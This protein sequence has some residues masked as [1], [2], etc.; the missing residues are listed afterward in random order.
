MILAVLMFAA[1][2]LPVAAAPSSYSITISNRNAGHIYEAYQVFSGSLET[3][4]GENVLVDITWGSGVNGSDL[5]ATLKTLT[6]GETTPFSGATSAAEVAE[7]LDNAIDDSE[8]AKAFADT[9]TKHLTTVKAVSTYQI[10]DYSISVS[11]PGYYLIKDQA[12]TMDGKNDTYTRRILAVADTNVSVEHKGT[13]PT[14]EKYITGSEESVS[15]RDCSI[16]DTVTFCLKGKLPDNYDDYKTYKY[17]F[18]DTLPEGLT[19]DKTSLTITVGN[20]NTW[21]VNYNEAT[22]QLTIT[23]NDLKAVAGVDKNTI[24]RVTYSAK[25]NEKAVLGNAGNT[26]TVYLEFSNDPNDSSKTGQTVT[27]TATV[28]TF[29]LNITKVDAEDQNKTLAGAEFKLKNTDGEFAKIDDN[30][31]VI[32]W[33]DTEAEG[34]TL[35]SGADGSFEIQ[36]LGADTYLLKETKAPAGYNRLEKQVTIIISYET[37]ENGVSSLT[38]KA[39]TDNKNLIQNTGDP[40]TGMI[41]IP[42]VNGKGALLPSTGGAGTTAFYLIGGVLVLGA[43]VLLVTKKRMSAH[44]SE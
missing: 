36:G 17:I 14:V 24:I 11:Q 4:D 32:G 31:K 25:L 8:L 5:L 28:Y 44:V 33:T 20:N 34:A 43:A 18:H 1:M 2:V 30:H 7:V 19:Y 39:G 40:S 37:D 15:V 9:A 35:V 41:T 21:D 3:V 38:A 6:V 23:C 26:N 10:Y 16:G 13:V 29:G 27:E 12:D 42:I 22:R